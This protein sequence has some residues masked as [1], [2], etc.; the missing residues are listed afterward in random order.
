MQYQD[1][2]T[3]GHE[4]IDKWFSSSQWKQILSEADEG[5]PD[6]LQL[7]ERVNEQLTSLLFHMKNDSGTTRVQY[8]LGYFSR[9]CDDFEVR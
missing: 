3:D 7:M 2:Y 1:G 4:L 8:E 9:L 6:S 5:D